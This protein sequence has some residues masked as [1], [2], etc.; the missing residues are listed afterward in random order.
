MRAN[1]YYTLLLSLFFPAFLVAQQGSIVGIVT[2]AKTNETII[3]ANV[4]LEATVTGTATNLD[5]YYQIPNIEPGTYNIVASFISYLSDTVRGVVVKA[6]EA[7]RLN[8]EMAEL[9]TAIQGV[10]IV[11]RRATSTEL[12]MIGSIKS[13]NI[14]VSGISRQQIS[15]SQDKNASEVLRRVPG[16]TIVDDRFVIV[17]GLIERY[18]SV[19]LNNSVTPS[20]EADQR[21]FS[22]DIIPSSMIDRILVYKTAAPELPADFAGA[23]IQVFTKN[24]PEENEL[25]ISASLRYADG[26]TGSD[27]YKYEGG[28]TDWLGFDDGTRKL[29]ESFNLNPTEYNQLWDTARLGNR[30]LQNEFVNRWNDLSKVSTAEKI[31]AL[32]NGKISAE[33]QGRFKTKNLTIGN[34]SLLSYS[35]SNDYKQ[36]FRGQYQF[37]R[38]DTLDQNPDTTN[39]YL[40]DS[41]ESKVQVG[42]LFNWSLSYGK[43]NFEFRN[44]FNQFGKTGTTFR[45]GID[46]YRS[47]FIN[48]SELYYSSK[49]IYSGQLSGQ[50]TVFNDF[51]KI[52]WTIG[53]ALARKEEPDIRRFYRLGVGFS[54]SLYKFDFTGNLDATLKGRLWFK[55]DE[56]IITGNLNYSTRFSLGNFSP[57][58]KAGAYY[59]KKK[60]D[61]FIRQLALS[62]TAPNEM[63]F[64]NSIEFQP[65]DSIY[66]SQN[67]RYYNAIND[68]TVQKAGIGYIDQTRGNTNYK[69]EN[70]LL[71]AYLGLEIPLTSKLKIYTG[72][73]MESFSRNLKSGYLSFDDIPTDTAT[74]LPKYPTDTISRDTVN[75]F[76]SINITYKF[77]DQHLLRLAYGK[78]INRAEFREIAPFAF[79]DFT[80]SR[81]TWGNDTLR[82][83]YIDNVDL[84]YEWYPTPNEMVTIGGFYKYF[85]SPIEKY[86]RPAGNADDIGVRNINFAKSFGVELDIRKSFANWAG[87]PDFLRYFKH[88]T[89]LFNASYIKSEIDTDDLYAREKNRPMMGQSPYI[90]NTGIYYNNPDIQLSASVLYNVIGE[91]IMIAGTQNQPNTYELPRDML[92]FTISKGIGE[93]LEIKAGI[94]NI[95]NESTKY[96]QTAL[97]DV[98]LEEDG[99]GNPIDFYQV[100][101]EQVIMEYKEGTSVMIGVSYR[102]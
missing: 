93:H 19:W 81:L 44:V 18:N 5:G 84:R 52:D 88:V 76:P 21:A 63:L 14:T 102:F 60:R 47:A 55:L 89:L 35:K 68:T 98:V 51:T 45:E 100:E 22:F 36:V 85:D 77:N 46:T 66:N 72:V 32:P 40:D 39:R 43:N 79:Y 27:F 75:F 95:L 41:Y 10:E 101:R 8:F 65:V 97:G 30:N 11:D 82:D 54:D 13:S 24:Y 96:T 29:P 69:A 87:R 73:R 3:G 50:H 94:K 70:N 33:Y 64:D 59:E 38:P 25:R 71:A 78:T 23:A 74:N 2:D 6:G 67:Y 48:F 15:R 28:K 57:G 7:T 58:I 12:A 62:F 49:T 9:S 16:I 37:Y 4:I 1:F 26:T 20:V 91:R 80:I 17:R 61:F 99:D 34:I 92:D 56:D 53:Y 90:I 86:Y 42:A 31:K 83:V